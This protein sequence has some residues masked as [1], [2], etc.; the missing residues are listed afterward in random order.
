MSRRPTIDVLRVVVLARSP[1]HGAVKKR[2]AASIGDDAALEA[3]REMLAITIEATSRA[4]ARTPGWLLEVR[5]LGPPWDV[6]RNLP[7]SP[8]FVP[9]TSLDQGRNLDEALEG[10]QGNEWS[11]SLV[12][13]ADH[14]TLEP[15]HIVEMGS[16]LNDHPICIGPCEDGGFWCV[17][18]SIPVRDLMEG[19]PLGTDRAMEGLVEKVEGLGLS[20]GKG[21]L[22]WDVD[23][24]DDLQRWRA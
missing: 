5:H 13:G 10:R 2:L 1:L 7:V 9:Q 18:A 19:V 20:W 21:P 11:A 15:D 17:G 14:P 24:A 16:L 3:Y 12:I 6:G 4:V 8:L 23:T 22:L